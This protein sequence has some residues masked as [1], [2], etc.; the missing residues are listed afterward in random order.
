MSK[1]DIAQNVNIPLGKGASFIKF[2]HL[3]LRN[4]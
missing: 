1:A 2:R 3:I 4:V